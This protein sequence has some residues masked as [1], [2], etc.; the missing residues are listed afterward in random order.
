M[1]QREDELRRLRVEH[2]GVLEEKERL[3]TEAL[4]SLAEKL[5]LKDVA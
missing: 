5:Q 2:Q 1:L 4:Q 3:A